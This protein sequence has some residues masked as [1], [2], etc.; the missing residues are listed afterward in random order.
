[1]PQN[2]KTTSGTRGSGNG[3]EQNT[4]VMANKVM[5]QAESVFTGEEQRESRKQM[6]KL[7]QRP[8]EKLM[9]RLQRSVMKNAMSRTNPA[10]H[11]LC[12]LQ[13]LLRL[14][15]LGRRSG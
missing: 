12:Q 15:V 11:G 9:C 4:I 13:R 1:M 10:A 8:S 7:R 3:A 14:N 2:G 6:E 5:S